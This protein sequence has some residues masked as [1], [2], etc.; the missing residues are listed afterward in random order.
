MEMGEVEPS[1]VVFCWENCF[2]YSEE[3]FPETSE[4]IIKLVSY[5][6]NAGYMAVFNHL[7]ARAF[8]A[9]WEEN[10]FGP[11]PFEKMPK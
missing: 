7:S 1:Q 9:N 4:K 11:N 5:I 2:E 3:T 8:V 6:V 10:V